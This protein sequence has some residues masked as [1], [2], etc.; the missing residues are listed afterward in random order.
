MRRV[1]RRVVG[2]IRVVDVAHAEHGPRSHRVRTRGGGPCAPHPAPSRLVA[3]DPS[4]PPTQSSISV[5]DGVTK[6]AF[7]VMAVPLAC[8]D[9]SASPRS[10]V[11]VSCSSPDPSTRIRQSRWTPRWPCSALRL[12]GWE[13]ASLECPQS[14]PP[15][16]VQIDAAAA[17]LRKFRRQRSR[18]AGRQVV[19][20]ELGQMNRAVRRKI[21]RHEK[22]PI[23]RDR[24]VLLYVRVVSTVRRV[25]WP[26]RVIT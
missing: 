6:A 8:T 11:W 1:R 13:R 3:H 20:D 2:E 15:L 25:R 26:S 23:G 10:V 12:S 14:N 16:A 9:T 21:I 4:A 24:D 22:Q 7:H 5:S 17:G 18:R 19:Q